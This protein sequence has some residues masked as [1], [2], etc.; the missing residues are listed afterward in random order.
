M[1]TKDLLFT[2]VSG[3]A[4]LT[5]LAAAITAAYLLRQPVTATGPRQRTAHRTRMRP[6]FWLGLA[7]PVLALAHAW[8]AMTGGSITHAN[9][10]GIDLASVAFLAAVSQAALGARLR[11]TSTGRLRH[12]HRYTMIAIVFLAIG[13]I[14]L[15]STLVR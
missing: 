8:P 5:V 6:H 3:W 2:V 1:L 10:V 9:Q 14:V 13:H 11:K 7:I 15:N 4:V 12:A